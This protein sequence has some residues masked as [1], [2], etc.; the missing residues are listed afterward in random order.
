VGEAET[1]PRWSASWYPERYRLQEI[2]TIHSK[3]AFR[4]R[5]ALVVFSEASAMRPSA[6]LAAGNL[7]V[8]SGLA[9]TQ[10]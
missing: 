8:G 6:F 3:K 4:P 10:M 5:I 9:P 1:T 2:L 7:N